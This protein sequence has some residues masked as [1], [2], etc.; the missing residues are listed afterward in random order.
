[1]AGRFEIPFGRGGV[2]VPPILR[3]LESISLK[4]IG[5]QRLGTEPKIPTNPPNGKPFLRGAGRRGG[6]AL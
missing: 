4:R 5:D 2:G 1:M 3:D 6:G